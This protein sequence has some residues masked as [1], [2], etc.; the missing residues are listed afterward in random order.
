MHTP[1]SSARRAALVRFYDLLDAISRKKS[2][3][4]GEMKPSDAPRDGVYFF[5]EPGEYRSGTGLGDRIVRVGSH[6]LTATSKATLLGRLRQHRGTNASG[7]NHR[8]SIF[9]LLIG[10]AMQR[11]DG[12][13][14]GSWGVGNTAN[15]DVRENERALEGTVSRYLARFA[16]TVVPVAERHHRKIIETWAISLLSNFGKEAIDPPSTEWLGYS[17]SREKV[18]KSGLW[19]NR[20]VDAIGAIDAFPILE[21]AVLENTHGI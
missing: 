5:F 10:D 13:A 17:S 18:R 21:R 15:A 16:V 20:D 8:G 2:F 19:N 3:R 11:R 4:L 1:D 9:R 12:V 14:T 6:A 7:G